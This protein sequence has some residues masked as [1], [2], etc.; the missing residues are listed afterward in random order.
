M[1][2]DR[3][4]SIMLLLQVNQRITSRELAE[5]LEV[6]ERTIHRDMEALGAA[7]I[8]IV[9]ERGSGGGWS[10]LEEYRTNLTGLSEAELQALFLA[11]PARVLNDLGLRQAAEAALIKL[12]AALPALARPDAE[13]ARQRIHIDGAGWRQAR[14]DVPFLPV[15]QEAVWQ[16]RKLQLSYQR[17]DDT[18]V[19]RLVEPLGLVAK[20][21]A[22]YL[23]AGVEDSIRTYRISRV[24]GATI[25]DQAAA[26]PPDFDLAAYWDASTARFQAN[27]PRYPATI[28]VD[29]AIFEYMGVVG[30]YARVV[31][32]KA[33]DADGWMTV[34]MLFEGERNACEHVLSFGPQIEVIAPARL[35]ELVIATA[36]QIVAR[37]EQLGS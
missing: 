31:D 12:R 23:I 21:S 15:I 37:Y 35:R 10:L 28:R 36:R 24:Q 18:A 32:A 7:G 17:A 11:Q 16:D 2:A 29:A 20:G 13:H 19:E 30:R 33:P 5:R 34:E 1:R 6:A 4:L 14:E 22:W 8:P 27:L 26:R 9:A 25:T 3:L